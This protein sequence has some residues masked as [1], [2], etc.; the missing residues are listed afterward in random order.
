[1]LLWPVAIGHMESRILQE[2]TFN[3]NVV[4]VAVDIVAKNA[5]ETYLAGRL[6]AMWT[7]F[8]FSS[9]FFLSLSLMN[10]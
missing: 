6:H 1:M 9:F 8:V 4:V 5:A 10:Q 3:A 2:S 7:G